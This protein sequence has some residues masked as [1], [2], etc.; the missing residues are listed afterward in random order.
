[1]TP[2]ND[3]LG[4]PNAEVYRLLTDRH[5]LVVLDTETTRQPPAA[6]TDGLFIQRLIQLGTVT[7]T[8]GATSRPTVRVVNPGVPVNN[9][10]IH[11]LTD[12]DVATASDFA[13]IVTAL[14]ALLD[15]GPGTPPVVL[16]CHY[17]PFDVHVLR[18]EYERLDR[19]MPNIV[20][21]DTIDLARHV[22]HDTGRRRSLEALAVSLDVTFVPEHDAGKDA[23]ATAACTVRLLR[24]AAA[25]GIF[26]LDDILDAIGTPAHDVQPPAFGRRQSVREIPDVPPEH[27][28]THTWTLPPEP[29]PDAIATWLRHAVACS[30]VCCPYAA[31]RAH[32]AAAALAYDQDTARHLL[33][34]LTRPDGLAS[35]GPGQAG[36]HAGLLAELVPAAIRG[37][38]EGIRW[39][40]TVRTAIN[41]LPRCRPH[42]PL[43][44][45]RTV[46]CPDCQEGR[47]CP[48]DT[49]HEAAAHAECCFTHD[50]HLENTTITRLVAQKDR[51]AHLWAQRGD[52]DIAG[53][54][55]WL[56]ITYLL[57]LG[58]EGRANGTLAKAVEV[59]VHRHDPRIALLHAQ[60]LLAQGQ[61]DQVPD[62]LA[63]CRRPAGNTNPGYTDLEDWAAGPYAEAL[64]RAQPPRERV[65]TK[66]RQSRPEARIRPNRLK[67]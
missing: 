39:W 10:R 1:M 34:V 60:T 57:S 42:Q 15:P 53:H 30:Q 67:P 50:D 62:A 25:A 47:P 28:P 46:A 51:G 18:A 63:G 27:L 48:L 45:G 8:G 19:Q 26:D 58:R 40:R 14:D 32:E 49:L 33:E 37:P 9:T 21:I 59:N 41:N 29:D 24:K 66:P 36:T 11:G 5:T 2:P 64:A 23:A 35:L 65:L 12:V 17:A 43:E 61:L 7:I 44:D 6:R 13:G 52:A 16:V 20:V 38:N 4:N 54:V 22:G 56:V 55:Y 31:D 3:Y